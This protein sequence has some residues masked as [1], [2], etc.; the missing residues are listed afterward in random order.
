[1]GNDGVGSHMR[2]TLLLVSELLRGAALDRHRAGTIAAINP[3]GAWS[4]LRQIQKH[5]DGVV[6]V[7][8]PGSRAKHMRFDLARHLGA[9]PLGTLVAACLGMGMATLFEKSAYGPAMR[10]AFE[11]LL[12]SA[13]DAP[14]FRD[15]DR[16]FAFVPR[17]GEVALERHPE[18]LEEIIAGLLGNRRL[19]LVIDHVHEARATRTVEPL[20][21]VVH[22]HQLYLL[23]RERVAGSRVRDIRALRVARI[24]SARR[25]KG[26]FRYP[27]RSDYD[28][29]RLFNEVF[30][31]YLRHPEEPARV[32]VRL[33]DRWAKYTR[34]HRW[35]PSQ[36]VISDDLERDEIVVELRVRPCPEVEAWILSL[37]RDAVVLEPDALRERVAAQIADMA[38]KHRLPAKPLSGL[39]ARKRRAS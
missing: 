16:K 8:L 21:L 19:R 39:A 34:T 25:Q 15:H 7:D 12:A 33:T 26:T 13:A 23:A 9:T 35:H 32:R 17:G 30:G 6:Q 5:L 27:E 2:T 22:H 14:L 28:P 31:I 29:A 18:V 38:R 11:K 36:H 37:G 3:Q 24:V 20:S 1:M 4:Q 10:A